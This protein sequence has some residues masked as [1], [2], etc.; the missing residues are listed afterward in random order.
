MGL[1]LLKVITLWDMLSI[2]VLGPFA[3]VQKAGGGE[4]HGALWKLEEVSEN[5][6]G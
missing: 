6:L 3:L 2:S 4:N 5:R 1:L